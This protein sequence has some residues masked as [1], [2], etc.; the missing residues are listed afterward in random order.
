MTPFRFHNDGTWAHLPVEA[1]RKNAWVEFRDTI[2][3]RLDVEVLNGLS[4]RL[5]G[6]QG[7]EEG[8]TDGWLAWWFGPG[9]KPDSLFEPYAHWDSPKQRTKLV[10][11]KNPLICSHVRH[12]RKGTH[13]F[14]DPDSKKEKLTGT[15]MEEVLDNHKE[16]LD[17]W[18]NRLHFNPLGIQKSGGF[19]IQTKPNTTN[20][21]GFFIGSGQNQIAVQPSV[22]KNAVFV[23]NP[24]SFVLGTFT[25]QENE[26]VCDSP[27]SSSDKGEDETLNDYLQRKLREANARTLDEAIINGLYGREPEPPKK[28][29][30]M[31]HLRDMRR[32]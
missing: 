10:A 13:F 9:H 29:N 16:A 19:S 14:H 24:N 2:G 18:R 31:E 22:V 21:G 27:D 15:Q 20:P 12:V 3:R 4:I 17:E 28:K 25:D 7:L 32:A 23:H 1:Q 26:T 30:L 6:A 11:C 8:H 5:M